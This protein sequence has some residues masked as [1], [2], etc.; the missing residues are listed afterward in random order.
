MLNI[1]VVD[2]EPKH[3]KG[4][5]RMLKAL[6]PEYNIF[7]AR[8]GAEALQSMELHR[9]DLVFTDI[10]MPVMDG[11][12]LMEHLSR[13][14]GN[15]CIIIMSAYSDFAYAQR[16]LQLGA[17]DYVLKPIEEQNVLP[18]L[19]KAEHKA[20]AVRLASVESSLSEMLEGCPS[21]EDYRLLESLFPEFKRG[22]VLTAV[23]G[24][25]KDHKL[26]LNGLKEKL[27]PMIG[28]LGFSSAFFIK[29]KMLAALIMSSEHS[30]MVI[31]GFEAKL[32]KAIQHFQQEYGAELT[33][34]FGRYFTEW[35]QEAKQA[36][37]QACHALKTRFY[38]G[39]G[40]VYEAE[41]MNNGVRPAVVKLEFIELTKAVLSG[42]KPEIEACLDSA[43]RQAVDSGFPEPEKLKYFLAAS[44]HQAT[45]LLMEKGIAPLH[46]A[47]YEETLLHCH[48][49]DELIKAARRWIFELM[50]RLEQRRQY[51]TG[52]IIDSCKAYIDTHYSEDDLSLSTL[53]IKFH[54]NPSYFCML[55]KTHTHMTV[56]QYITQTRMKVAAGLLLQTSQKVYQIAELVG[57]KDVKYFIRLFRKEFGSS[58]EEYRHLSATR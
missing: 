41:P 11:L 3:R 47:V 23:F 27:A 8:D 44:I 6:K 45:A 43:V 21:D 52:S 56:H 42:N 24:E 51:K 2:D 36:Y 40:A 30:S 53:A 32:Q 35:R 58:P 9:M 28:E 1:L 22:I 5:S 31:S 38:K 12:E 55:F 49:V 48:T 39:G 14:G 25:V 37:Q 54:F 17:S 26:L 7:H 16:A 10:Q 18:L 33:F 20:S 34:G 19:A 50:D 15:E 57:Y 29:D 13:R 4:M 46:S